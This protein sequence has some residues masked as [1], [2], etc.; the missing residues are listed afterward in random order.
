MDTLNNKNE[1]YHFIESASDETLQNFLI[2]LKNG[3]PH[4]TTLRSDLYRIM[5]HNNELR[6]KLS[7]LMV[8][9]SY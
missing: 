6:I 4:E 8:D 7:E 9:Y 3:N 1:L 5:E 2:S